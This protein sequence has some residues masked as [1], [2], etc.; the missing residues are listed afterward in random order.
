MSR[1]DL[2]DA[3]RH[4]WILAAVCLAGLVLVLVPGIGLAVKG[5]RRW[6]GFGPARLQISEFA[7]LAMVFGLAHYLA[8]NQ[9]RIQELV[10]G[11]LVPLAG[12]SLCSGLILLEP[13]FGTA[14]LVFAIGVVLLFLAGGRAAL[15][16]HGIPVRGR[17]C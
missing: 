4:V 1:V 11:F 13:D 7:K 16:G 14:A 6:L 17:A 15:S 3:R 5:S 2:E 12:I 9:T 8:L 10:R